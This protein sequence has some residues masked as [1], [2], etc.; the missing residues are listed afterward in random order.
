MAARQLVLARCGH[1]A[2]RAPEA[3]AKPKAKPAK[4]SP[5]KTRGVAA[6]GCSA[7]SVAAV[8]AEG[9]R[10]ALNIKAK[11]SAKAGKGKRCCEAR[12]LCWGTDAFDMNDPYC[13]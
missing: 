2:S 3:K 13:P 9:G 7:P 4:G 10:S 6:E 12:G 5:Q 11:G 8:A 1:D